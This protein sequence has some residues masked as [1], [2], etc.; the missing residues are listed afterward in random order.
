MLRM[1]VMKKLIP[2]LLIFLIA[3]AVLASLRFRSDDAP[4]DDGLLRLYGNVDIREVQLAFN[5][6]E[7]IREILVQEGDRVK[8]GQ[9]LARLNTRLIEAQLAEAEAA[10]EAQRQAL[11]KLEAGSRPEEIRKVEAELQAAEAQAKA[12]RDSYRRIKRLLEQKLVSPQDEEQARSQADAAEAQVRAIRESLALL[13]LGA[14]EED[15]AAA[16]AQLAAREAAR[17]QVRQRLADA[18]LYAPADGVI[19]NRIL[20]PGDM[21]F[22]Q[23]PVMT[24]AFV[25]PVWVRAYLPEPMLGRVRLGARA[26]ITTDSYPDK[27]YEGWVGYVSPTAEFTPKTVQTP[28]LRTRL[29]YSVRVF[30]CNPQDELR[31]GMPVSVQIELDAA[32]GQHAGRPCGDA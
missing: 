23:T 18:S 29:V 30:A 26:W 2:V 4:G 28:E 10:V 7:R 13:R 31:L 21:A 15:V 27:R 14:R 9:R 8:K 5:G 20:E 19:R 12:A 3:G 11:A 16:R 24:L 25:D 32:A 1:I 22:P 6:S 17:E